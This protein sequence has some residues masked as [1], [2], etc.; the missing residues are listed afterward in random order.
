MRTSHLFYYS[1]LELHVLGGHGV[2]GPGSKHSPDHV[3]DG[4]VPQSLASWCIFLICASDSLMWVTSICVF[5]LFVTERMASSDNGRWKLHSLRAFSCMSVYS[6]SSFPATINQCQY[7]Q[8]RSYVCRSYCLKVKR[9]C[10]LG[11]EMT[12]VQPAASL[13]CLLVHYA[14]LDLVGKL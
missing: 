2:T 11:V 8:G 3:A 1:H 6:I 4:C 10:L 14:L 7:T 9:D 12:A 5:A 13:R